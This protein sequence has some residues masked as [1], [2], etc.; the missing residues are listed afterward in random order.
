MPAPS[1]VLVQAIKV[2]NALPAAQRDAWA[3]MFEHYVVQRE[4]EP[5]GHI[6]EAWHGVLARRR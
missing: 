5:A 4:Q 6:P 3:A 1:T 2:L